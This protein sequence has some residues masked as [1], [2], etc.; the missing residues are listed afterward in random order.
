MPARTVPGHAVLAALLSV[1]V[2]PSCGVPARSPSPAPAASSSV[3]Q[4]TSA[5]PSP[6]DLPR[7]PA[8]P[9]TAWVQV[10]VAT[11]WR[12]PRSP[13][14]VDRPALT[15]P[16]AIAR[17]LA[18]MTTED[19]RGLDGRADSQV[20]MGQTVLVVGTSGTWVRVVVPSQPTPLDRRGYPGWIPAVQLTFRAPP[21]AAK[22]A[23]VV[24]PTSRTTGSAALSL[25]FGTTLPVVAASS[26]AVT[27]ALPGG[28]R[29]VL[30]ARD[31]VVHASGTGALA[32][33]GAGIVGSARL[34]RGL[35]YLWAGT[36]GFG[37]DCSGLVNLVA[38]VHGIRL[39][40]DADA[41]ARAGRAVAVGSVRPGDLLFF[42]RDGYVHHVAI[43]EGAGRMIEAPQTG[44]A[45]REVSTHA[46]PSDVMTARRITSR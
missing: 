45:V 24:R 20:L 9:R 29:A 3:Q 7:S 13:R 36:S 6:T 16:A 33:T 46:H 31:V 14:T 32:P 12:S 15:R 43:Y 18:G 35:A 40:R 19:R 25:S 21:T 30:A 2:V 38:R 22:V 4:P 11:L 8:L 27:V 41:Q 5:A 17:W 37:F 28:P 1:V 44:M 42:A 39:P 26:R 23:T 34:F 10:S